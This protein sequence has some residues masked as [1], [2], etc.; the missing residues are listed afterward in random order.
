MHPVTPSPRPLLLISWSR[1]S[2]S[3]FLVPNITFSLT[4]PFSNFAS[5][6]RSLS[7]SQNHTFVC[8]SFSSFTF[9]FLDFTFLLYIFL[10][11]NLL[12]FFLSNSC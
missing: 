2:S 5:F 8:V 6:S 11:L 9:L 7:L 4:F 10:F 1:H 12:F 3:T